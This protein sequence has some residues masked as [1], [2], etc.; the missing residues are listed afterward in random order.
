MT[1]MV[2]WSVIM[3]PTCVNYLKAGGPEKEH[4]A[5]TI[6]QPGEFG[7]GQKEGRDTNP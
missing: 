4:S 6:N 1:E 2:S 5:S 3:I 7:R